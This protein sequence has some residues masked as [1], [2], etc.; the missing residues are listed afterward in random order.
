[1]FGWNH[2]NEAGS[3]Q[4]PTAAGPQT[5]EGQIMN[6][7]QEPHPTRPQGGPDYPAPGAGHPYAVPQGLDNTR[8]KSPVL[9]TMLSS[10]PGLGQ[11]YVGYYQTGFLYALTIAGCIAILNMPGSGAFTAFVGI[12][13]AFFWIFNM[14]DAN[15]RAMFYNRSMVGQGEEELPDG[16]PAGRKGSVPAGVILV[17]LG[18]LFILDLNFGVSMEWIEDWWP[19]ALVAFGGWLVYKGRRD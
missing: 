2:G 1:M 11:I 17:A 4:R 19:L 9:A 5:Q 10:F 6:N 12:F 3:A 16:F 7:H 8:R 18:V 14:I 13:L 15:R